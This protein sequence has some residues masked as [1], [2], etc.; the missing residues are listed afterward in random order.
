MERDWGLSSILTKSGA[1]SLKTGP[2]AIQK[3][4]G[5]LKL[6]FAIRKPMAA[7]GG[8]LLTGNPLARQMTGL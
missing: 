1:S 4:E 6:N 5:L 3:G 7:F 2:N 8:T